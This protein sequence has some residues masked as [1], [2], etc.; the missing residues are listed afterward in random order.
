MALCFLT[1][2]TG[3]NLRKIRQPRAPEPLTIN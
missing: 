1:I 3:P 2:L